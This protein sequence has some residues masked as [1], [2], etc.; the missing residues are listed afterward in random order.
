MNTVDDFNFQ[1]DYEPDVQPDP[2]S[3]EDDYCEE[4]FDI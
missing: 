3:R 1:P 2:P 4:S